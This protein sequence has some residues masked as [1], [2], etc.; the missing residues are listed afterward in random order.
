ML[1]GR[2]GVPVKRRTRKS[3]R[4]QHSR[5][6]SAARLHAGTI[7]RNFS[8]RLATNWVYD[9]E[10]EKVISQTRPRAPRRGR[11]NIAGLDEEV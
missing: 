11:R 2:D 4:Q 10:R 9:D 7:E 3:N 8:R 6:R 1:P 5:A